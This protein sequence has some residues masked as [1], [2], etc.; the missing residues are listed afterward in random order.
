[1]K[2]A[3]RHGGADEVTNAKLEQSLKGIYRTQY[4]GEY[5]DG[6]GRR[7]PANRLVS[8]IS[9]IIGLTEEEKALVSN[10]HYITSRLAGTRQI[11][12]HIGHIV[13]SGMIIYGNPMSLTVTPSERH[14]GLCIRLTLVRRKDLAPKA[15]IAQ[16]F[17]QHDFQSTTILTPQ[18]PTARYDL[19]R[20]VTGRDPLCFVLAFLRTT[21]HVLPGLYGWRSCP[22]CPDCASGGQP[23]MNIYGSN[24]APMGGSL[25]RIGA[26]VGAFE[27]QKAEG[28]LHLQMFMFEE[29][30]HQYLTLHLIAE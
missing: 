5:M 27:M 16:Q 21:K 11:R 7:I 8:H 9:Q 3:T 4:D 28:V 26:A 10:F 14:S 23:C 1:M 2:P 18:V 19:R 17:Q 6:M 25:G 22:T 30:A 20:A 29:S 15:G 13:K 24:A 12:R